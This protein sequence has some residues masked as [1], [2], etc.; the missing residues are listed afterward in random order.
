MRTGLGMGLVART[1]G[2]VVTTALLASCGAVPRTGPSKDDIYASSVLRE[3]DAFVVEVNN[4][5]T[6]AT[7]VVPTLGFSSQLRSAAPLGADTIRRGDTLSLVVYEN[8]ENGLLATGGAPA[9]AINEVQVDDD[10]F[11]FIP[12]AGRVQASGNTPEALRRIITERLAEQTPDPQVVVRRVAGDGATVSIVGLAGAQGIYPI[13][14]PTQ[15]LSAALATA[16]GATIP[17]DVALVSLTRNGRTETA[18]LTDIYGERDQDIALRDGDTIFIEQDDRTFTALGATGTQT[19]LEFATEVVTAID[20]IAQV[21]GLNGNLANPTGIFVFRNEPEPIA[22]AVL[23]RDDLV[24]PQR[25]IYVLDMTKPGGLFDA[26]DF[27]IRDGDTIYVTEARIVAFNRSVAA[28]FGSLGQ[29]ANAG[30]IA[31]GLSGN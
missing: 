17:P 25:M 1:T 6:Q 24:G 28:L 3:G 7:A 16:G 4:R 20:A 30:N 11:I 2:I 22:E 29:L 8:V 5:V 10:G 18:R 9:A 23:G 27:V 31:S 15:T 14:R 13:Q 12:Y 19:R 21:G 26:R